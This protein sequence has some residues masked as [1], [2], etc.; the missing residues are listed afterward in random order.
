[1]SSRIAQR[2]DRP[3]A[4]PG[5][6]SASSRPTRTAWPPHPRAAPRLTATT[7]VT[8]HQRRPATAH[9]ARTIRATSGYVRPENGRLFEDGTPTE[10]LA[11]ALRAR[12]PEMPPN[13]HQQPTLATGSNLRT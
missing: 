3:Q 12:A 5:P 7:A 10:S 2:W 13:S 11:Y 8:G 6:G 1:M 9:N 4:G